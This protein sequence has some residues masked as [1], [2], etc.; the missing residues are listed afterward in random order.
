ML[1][2]QMPNQ[3]SPATSTSVVPPAINSFPATTPGGVLGLSWWD[4]PL[5]PSLTHHTQALVDQSN[6]TA[7]TASYYTGPN[8]VESNPGAPTLP[9][10]VTDVSHDPNHDGTTL[11]G[12]GFRSGTYTDVSG[13]TPLTGAPATELNGVHSPFI[14]SAFFPSRLWSVNYFGG[15]TGGAAS[16]LLDLTPAQYKSDGPTSQTDVER[17][18]SG[19]T[20]RLYY[21]GNTTTYDGGTQPALAAAPTISRVDATVVGGKVLFSLHVVGDPNAGIQEVWVTYTGVDHPAGAT[22]EWE[23]LDLTQDPADSTLWTG[24]TPT[25]TPDQIAALKF[26]V[27]ATNGVGLVSLDDNQGNLYAPDQIPPALQVQSANITQTTLA[28]DTPPTD[29]AYGS[30]VPVSATLTGPGSTLV[31]GEQVTFSIGGS[32]ASAT[33]GPDGV[34]SVN[35]PLIDLPGPYQVTAGFNGDTTH[36]SSSDSAGFTI[37]KL[38]T[39]LTATAGAPILTGFDTGVTAS[40]LNGST[41][42]AQRSVAFLLHPSSGGADVVK[43]AITD[44]Y[45]N[46]S[47]GAIPNLAPGTYTVTAYFGERRRLQP[48]DEQQPHAHRAPPA[49]RAVDRPRSGQPDEH[50]VRGMDGHLLPERHGRHGGRLLARPDG[51]HRRRE[52]QRHAGQR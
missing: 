20:L 42:L 23:S 19:V 44:L 11:R 15:L 10:S 1:S 46:A 16:T 29:A 49:D 5:S 26:I 50:R 28:L 21:S 24:T 12:V 8:G 4:L 6:N 13:V 31:S 35:L 38:P 33:T 32:T 36:T 47:L 30:S 37:D 22:G 27:Q 2:V 39:S 17:T 51:R 40:L 43:T 7:G 41:G 18:F 25:L 14:S 34:A 3:V 52:P 45:G 48:D 9:L